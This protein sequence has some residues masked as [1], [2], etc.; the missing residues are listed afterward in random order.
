MAETII[1][2]IQNIAKKAG[3]Q[4]GDKSL[5]HITGLLTDVSAVEI[6]DDLLELVRQVIAAVY[7]VADDIVKDLPAAKALDLVTKIVNAGVSVFNRLG[8]FSKP[9]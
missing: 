4:E 6:P 3:I 9:A 5:Q 7:E 8:V 2:F 1:Q